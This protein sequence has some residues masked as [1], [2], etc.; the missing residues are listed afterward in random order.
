MSMY[1]PPHE[2]VSHERT[3]KSG[4]GGTETS[5]KTT[6]TRTVYTSK[7]GKTGSSTSKT[8]TTSTQQQNGDLSS[9]ESIIINGDLNG[10]LTDTSGVHKLKDGAHS[11]VTTTKT[12]S[13][14]SGTS[15]SKDDESIMDTLDNLMDELDSQEQINMADHSMTSSTTALTSSA[16]AVTSSVTS[17]DRK[18]SSSQSQKPKHPVKK[19]GSFQLKSA[20]YGEPVDELVTSPAASDDQFRDTLSRALGQG[21]ARAA[22]TSDP[23]ITSITS[24]TST[25]TTR[26][27]LQSADKPSTSIT[28]TTI[29]R[30]PEIKRSGASYVESAGRTGASYVDSAARAG[31]GSS[32][33]ITSPSSQHSVS[34]TSQDVN[35]IHNNTSD[36]KGDFSTINGHD[37]SLTST[38]ITTITSRT[39]RDTSLTQSDTGSKKESITGQRSSSSPPTSR[40]A[41]ITSEQNADSDILRASSKTDMSRSASVDRS[42]SQK[43]TSSMFKVRDIRGSLSRPTSGTASSRNSGMFG[44]FDL[45]A[46]PDSSSTIDQ[47]GS[48]ITSETSETSNTT[49]SRASSNL[50]TQS[51]GIKAGSSSSPSYMASTVT[52]STRSSVTAR[53]QHPGRKSST[54]ISRTSSSSTSASSKTATAT[55]STAGSRPGSAGTGSRPGSAKETGSRPGSAKETGSRPG[56]AKET[57]SRPGS[58]KETGSAGSRAT[59]GGSRPTSAG[60][61]PT[62]AGGSSR[63]SRPGSYI[64]T[65][66]IGITRRTSTDRE[67]KTSLTKTD[68]QKSG[69]SSPRKTSIG[70]SRSE[71]QKSRPGSAKSTSSSIG[72]KSST[73]KSSTHEKPLNSEIQTETQ[74]D[75]QKRQSSDK[76]ERNGIEGAR[77]DLDVN[78]NNI[79]IDGKR[80]SSEHVET[81][82]QIKTTLPAQ[83]GSKRASGDFIIRHAQS[84]V[85]PGGDVT[86]EKTYT[87]HETTVSG[88]SLGSTLERKGETSI[89]ST[90]ERKGEFSGSTGSTLEKKGDFGGSTGSISDTSFIGSANALLDDFRSGRLKST[91]SVESSLERGSSTQQ[92]S[93]TSTTHTEQLNQ[94]SR[95]HEEVSALKKDL[96]LDISAPYLASQS[97]GNLAAGAFS[98]PSSHTQYINNSLPSVPQENSREEI[99]SKRPTSPIVQEANEAVTPGTVNKLSKSLFVNLPLTG[100]YIDPSTASHLEAKRKAEDAEEARG[101]EGPGPEK[102]YKFLIEGID[103]PAQEDTKENIEADNSSPDIHKET[104]EDSERGSP[105]PK[106][107][108][109]FTYLLDRT[110]AGEIEKRAKDV[111]A[112]RPHEVVEEKIHG[113]SE[114]GA[115]NYESLELKEAKAKLHKQIIASR[116]KQVGEEEIGALSLREAREKLNKQILSRGHLASSK[117]T[118]SAVSQ[119]EYIGGISAQP[120][121]SD[122]DQ[123][124]Y[125]VKSQVPYTGRAQSQAPYE[126]TSQSQVYEDHLYN[127]SNSHSG[128]QQ[129]YGD[130]KSSQVELESQQLVT[131]TNQTSIIK[132]TSQTS[133][134]TQQSE[135]GHTHS[136]AGITGSHIQTGHI[137]QRAI[138]DQELSS[139]H[140]SASSPVLIEDLGEDLLE[141]FAGSSSR[142]NVSAT[143]Q[144]SNRVTNTYTTSYTSSNLH[145]S[146]PRGGEA[147]K[148]S[149]NFSKEDHTLHIPIAGLSSAESDTHVVVKSTERDVHT[150][151]VG[152]FNGSTA[153]GS[154]LGAASGINVKLSTAHVGGARQQQQHAELTDQLSP[155]SAYNSAAASANP[156][157]GFDPFNPTQTAG[158]GLTSLTAGA[159]GLTSVGPA[160]DLE[161]TSEGKH[162]SAHHFSPEPPAVIMVQRGEEQ[163]VPHVGAG[164][165]NQQHHYKSEKMMMKSSKVSSQTSKQMVNGETVAQSESRDLMERQMQYESSG[166]PNDE[167][168]MVSSSRNESIQYH[169]GGSRGMNGEARAIGGGGSSRDYHDGG[170]AINHPIQMNGDLNIRGGH[171]SNSAPHIAASSSQDVYSDVRSKHGASQPHRMTNRDHTQATHTQATHTQQ[172]YSANTDGYGSTTAAG[173]RG[174]TTAGS[175]AYSQQGVYPST[176]GREQVTDLTRK[177][178]HLSTS[179]AGSAAGS[180]RVVQLRPLTVDVNMANRGGPGGG[181]GP[182]GLLSPSV[183]HSQAMYEIHNMTGGGPTQ[184]SQYNGYS[185]GHVNMNGMDYRGGYNSSSTNRMYTRHAGAPHRKYLRVDED[186]IPKSPYRDYN[187][188]DIGLGYR[189]LEG[190]QYGSGRRAQLKA[191]RVNLQGDP[192]FSDYDGGSVHS[193]P[194]TKLQRRISSRSHQRTLGGLGDTRGRMW[195]SSQPHIHNANI[196]D[197]AGYGGIHGQAGSPY[198]AGASSPP[199]RLYRARSEGMLV[200]AAMAAQGAAVLSPTLTDA[201]QTNHGNYHITLKLN[202]LNRGALDSASSQNSYDNYGTLDY[203]EASNTWNYKSGASWQRTGGKDPKASVSLVDIELDNAMPNLQSQSTSHH[204]GP[205]GPTT[206]TLG[207]PGQQQS[208]DAFSHLRLH[209]THEAPVQMGTASGM[210][211]NEQQIVST[212]IP[213][214][215]TAPPAGGMGSGP[216][217][218]AMQVNQTMRMDYAPKEKEEEPEEIPQVGEKYF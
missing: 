87:V 145:S 12:T 34:T 4:S 198:G 73:S 86:I 168:L 102:K 15:K 88:A 49:V 62:S 217:D 184:Y 108:G 71:S 77:V 94:V 139:Q 48:A 105:D 192:Y 210:V 101:L 148:T 142:E 177:T 2:G 55:A 186:R 80:V 121:Y 57:G 74:T 33:R 109:G 64:K 83:S 187:S 160:G 157:P 144:R 116:S 175:G 104:G 112:K 158:A 162:F 115:G 203:G 38:Q 18:S 53:P 188:N 180:G 208:Q 174:A 89:G 44:S 147:N 197:P 205:S 75:Q 67:R 96:K 51:T 204:L 110:L 68:S 134:H 151:H 95:S 156:S 19:A 63:T 207:D 170:R 111:T 16:P 42:S 39:S 70:S 5:Y 176:A 155:D 32:T 200:E 10:S 61:R 60:S 169:G 76:I 154:G 206:V 45:T 191:A 123:S 90:L 107:Q 7:G 185:P 106:T 26:T 22:T 93:K 9:R 36:N 82:Q 84:T 100:R 215:N 8:I 29:T 164:A 159:G 103:I 128:Q 24:Y 130:L 113:K 56:S 209:Q 135:P 182:S 213:R 97:D 212:T 179:S 23:N 117:T 1:D 141:D 81:K 6:T 25:E 149:R 3:G 40:V 91:D 58:A 37:P 69:P 129:S 189:D 173:F 43:S 99:F 150:S 46:A 50:S 122:T 20:F 137:E 125:T 47:A 183:K 72:R 92:L 59:S 199:G 172:G 202:Q 21:Q 126:G 196:H 118:E 66:E 201:R 132:T 54:T 194:M 124:P 211:Q 79:D 181:G 195:S 131:P 52:S 143:D 28:T 114:Y 190:Y 146:D 14:T 171:V 165:P 178:S 120:P 30:Q 13:L 218:F 152:S 136:S 31:S 167:G 98:Y 163:I 138:P 140:L 161:V 27:S 216:A 127:S 193:E 85:S 133:S 214:Q 35:I 65:S 41:S 17:L 11:T 78:R 119:G 166:L 153:S